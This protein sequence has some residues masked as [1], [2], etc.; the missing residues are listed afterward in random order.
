MI[1]IVPAELIELT[2]KPE[3]LIK[4][5][6]L[7]DCDEND[8][9]N[10]FIENS[11]PSEENLLTNQ[12]V[13]S[14]LD[15]KEIKIYQKSTT[16]DESSLKR[17]RSIDSNPSKRN[18]TGFPCKLCN[19]SYELQ[20]Q[21]FLHIKT[22][23]IKYKSMPCS[24]SR[25]KKND[26][27]L[28]DP[29]VQKE[30]ESML[31]LH[32]TNKFI[33]DSLI[34]NRNLTLP[35][36]QLQSILAKIRRHRRES[37]KPNLDELELWL[38]NNSKIPEDNHQV[39]VA[40]RESSKN[41][42]PMNFRFMLTTKN[43]INVSRQCDI[44]HC[45]F[46]QKPKWHG[47]LVF[48]IGTSDRNKNF[49]SFGIVITPSEEF[50]DYVFVFK[51]LKNIVRSLFS[52]D[53]ALNLL[54]C[55]DVK[56]K[57][58]AFIH[59][60]GQDAKVRTCWTYVKRKIRLQIQKSM[61]KS[62]QKAILEDIEAL[63]RAGTNLVFDR[64]CEKFLD[65][66]KRKKAFIS[67]FKEKW[68]DQNRLWYLGAI[69]GTPATNKALPSFCNSS[70]QF[71]HSA[72]PVDRFITVVTDMIT[73]WSEEYILI[74]KTFSKLPTVSTQMWVEAYKWSQ[75]PNRIL[76]MNVVES[77]ECYRVP[78]GDAS[79]GEPLEDTW[80]TFDEYKKPVRVQDVEL[81]GNK[82]DW[83]SGTCKCPTF[84]KDFACKHLVGL[85][86][87]LQRAKLPLEAKIEL[88]IERNRKL[89]LRLRKAILV[90]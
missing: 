66:W 21:L 43:L 90:P 51:S 79:E 3:P 50:D 22:C 36:Y 71:N 4:E 68:M 46:I 87:H 64:A 44:L 37:R 67:Y 48:V 14:I 60:F 35:M 63:Q 24:S 76:S 53:L 70:A 7:S 25:S 38:I 49:H 5:E 26:L 55:D 62:S 59:V 16:P 57:K 78:D 29:E 8:S 30:I 27:K 86:I 73:K 69:P 88:Q 54:L 56:M 32:H 52:F 18:K 45:D 23:H 84:F 75:I 15:N 72:L 6:L 34:Q 13:E 11:L 40:N 28:I 20:D 85:A 41:P 19:V 39:F 81:P 58:D 65:K 17:K 80:E 42:Y 61:S 82:A 89:P 2:I 9:N 33:L 31:D 10:F 1:Y 83:L 12:N 47:C 74:N 77:N